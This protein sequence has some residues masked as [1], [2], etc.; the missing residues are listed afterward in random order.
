M[1]KHIKM[2]REAYGSPNGIIIV[3]YGADYKGWVPERLADIFIQGGDAVEVPGAVAAEAPRPAAP[4]REDA[5]DVMRAAPTPAS[6]A[7]VHRT[8][9]AKPRNLSKSE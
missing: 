5:D 6:A 7:K 3:K 2:L 1:E 4:V 9:P 8:A